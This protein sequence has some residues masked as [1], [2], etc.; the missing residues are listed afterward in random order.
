LTHAEHEQV[1]DGVWAVIAKPDRGAVGN[2]A[3]VDLDGE[4]LVVDT[5]LA[6]AAARELCGAADELTGQ[7]A[8]LVLNT[9]WHSDHV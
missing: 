7:P 8:T 2:A 5:H 1:A 3:I 4:T 6:P 9:H